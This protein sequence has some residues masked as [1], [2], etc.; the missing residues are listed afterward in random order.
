M[1]TITD[2]GTLISYH[3]GIQG[4]CPIIRGTGVTVRRIAI[5]YKQGLTAE[6]IVSR[7]GYL[8]LNQVYAALT[9]YHSNRDE[10]DAEIA[11]EEAE[12]EPIESRHHYQTKT[13]GDAQVLEIPSSPTYFSRREFMTLPIE[14]RRRI[15]AE[16]TE[17]MLCHYQEDK[18][19]QELQTGDL[20]DY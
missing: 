12:A 10:I 15:L 18:E 6:E 16:Q 5:Y 7:M 8:T 4:G 13:Q 1:S 2:I 3:P 19:W 20:I 17:V 11:A 14:E 9:Y